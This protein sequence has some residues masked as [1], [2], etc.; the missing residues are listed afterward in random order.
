MHHLVPAATLALLAAP[1]ADDPVAL[2]FAPAE[3]LRLEREITM[4][5]SIVS[6]DLSV[7]MGGQEVPQ[8]FLPDLTVEVEM[9]SAV[10]LRDAFV[11][12]GEP[13]AGLARERTITDA[14]QSVMFALD[15]GG[16]QGM[17]DSEWQLSADTPL[18]GTPFLIGTD[19]EGEHVAR[20][21]DP[22]SSPEEALLDD[23][24]PDLDLQELLPDERVTVGARW[25]AGAAPLGMLFQPGG[26]LG[27]DWADG[28]QYMPDDA[29]YD[30]SGELELRLAEI[31]TVDGVE[32]ARIELSGGLVSVETS[33]TTLD[34]VPVTD[35][36]ATEVRTTT[37]GI[38]GELLWNLALGV[39]HSLEIEAE[40]EGD[41]VTTRDPDQPGQD[42]ESTMVHE[43]SFEVR[44]SCRPL[45]D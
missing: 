10:T 31:V 39:P 11:T 38:E 9:T 16:Y 25:K 2:T 44:L 32:L 36:T 27:W 1:T 20:W 7:V 22:E 34:E 17:E 8:S 45:R 41:Q 30:N 21:S 15:A 24:R 33:A 29:T 37:Y 35:G 5:Q 3:G 40:G 42:Y 19:E 14:G 43:S 28:E 26:D 13:F 23:L 6:G 12:P 4:T 18:E